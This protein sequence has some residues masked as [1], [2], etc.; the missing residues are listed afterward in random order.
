MVVIGGILVVENKEKEILLVQERDSRKWNFPAGTR[1][2]GEDIKKCAIREGF[3]E[4]GF[5]FE[6]TDAV[7]I[8]QENSKQDRFGFVF[9][10]KIIGGRKTIQ[11]EIID[12]QWFSYSEMEAMQ[13]RGELRSGYIIAVMQDYLAEKRLPLERI[14]IF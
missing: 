8:Y 5:M 1:D 10:A 6:L 14:T 7:G 9:T 2:P 4:T 12:V 13:E 11:N 3:E